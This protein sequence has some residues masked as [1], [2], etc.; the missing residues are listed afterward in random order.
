[1]P[2]EIE[3]GSGKRLKLNSELM[4][5]HFAEDKLQFRLAVGLCIPITPA[6]HR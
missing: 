6:F 3:D 5:Y 2:I 1:M 4:T